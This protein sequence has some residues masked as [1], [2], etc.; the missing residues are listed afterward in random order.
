MEDSLNEGYPFGGS[1]NKGY[2]IWGPPSL[3]NYHVSFG[4]L[5]LRC[6]VGFGVLDLGF[7]GL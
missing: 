7:E 5:G 3:G 2:L 6:N 4:V 1:K